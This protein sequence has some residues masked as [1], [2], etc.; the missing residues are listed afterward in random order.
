[1]DDA[2]GKWDVVYGGGSDIDAM[3]RLSTQELLC[4]TAAEVAALSETAAGYK[5][6]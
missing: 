3:L 2:V 1:M 5:N 4:A 6:R